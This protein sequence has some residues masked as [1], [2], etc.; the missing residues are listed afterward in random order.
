MLQTV[1]R[2]A[3]WVLAWCVVTA[4]GCVGLARIELAQLRD[5]FETDARIAHRLISQR[6]VQHDAV[7]ATLALLQPVGLPA[8]SPGG[9]CR[10]RCALG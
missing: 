8:D 10:R 4:L 9:A 2:H 3:L 5:D 1:R 6:V 7:L